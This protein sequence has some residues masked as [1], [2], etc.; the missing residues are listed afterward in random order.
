MK[1]NNL[2]SKGLNMLTSS[3]PVISQTLGTKTTGDSE[4]EWA[5]RGAF[6]RLNY[7][8]SERYLFELNGRYDGT[9]K[10]P[11]DSRY[12]LFPSVSA[13]W[14]ISEELFF[15]NI[16]N[17]V[18]N[19]KIRA[20][21]GSLGN[22]NVSNYIYFPSYGTISKV[23]YIFNGIR[24]MGVTAPG[25]VSPDLT[26]ETATTI[27]FG[28]DISLIHKLDFTFDWYNRT[29][30]DILVA[31]DKFPAVLGTSA[32]T[33]N[34]G[35][36]K[37]VGWEITSS[38][39][40]RFQ[41]GFQ[42]NITLVLSDYQSEITQFDGNPAKLLSSLYVGQKMG[43]IWGYETMGL[44]QSAEEIT[45]APSQKKLNSGVWYPGDVRYKNL[46]DDESEIYIGSNTAED[47]GD[48]R[49]IGNNTPRYQF[50]I[51]MNASWKNLDL[52]LFLQGVGKRDFWTND[53][54]YWGQI[55][56]DGV[57]TWYGYEN[58][59]TP[60]NK[61]AFFP[62]YRYFTGNTQVQ[63]R[64]L[65]NAAYIRFKNLTLGYTIPANITRKVTIEKARVYITGQNIWEATKIIKTLD[66]ET[67]NGNYPIM[68]SYAF[69]IQVSF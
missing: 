63:T 26:W 38:W 53:K 48:R 58:S 65:Q 7:N 30:T 40:D 56:L 22:Q 32:P 43:E 15:Q 55:L 44:F 9:S 23:G 68:R 18:N 20:S 50:G 69:G 8:Y 14:R 35:A 1:Y 49:I 59:W 13:G 3:L 21:Y 42:Y 2:W 62:G 46:D 6:F 19:L 52:N 33:K 12:K 51:D 60:Q 47:P 67:V 17:T 16:K 27:D 36:M 41:N 11:T 29:T 24:P 37:S 45:G 54:F 5:I 4:S 25:L 64:Y 39:R 66:P 28:F 57:G 61:D 10:F 34:S 31:G